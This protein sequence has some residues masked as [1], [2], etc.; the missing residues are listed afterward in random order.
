[1]TA[2]VPRR[3]RPN[4]IDT[5]RAQAMRDCASHLEDLKRAHGRPPADVRV[6]MT[7][8][9]RFIAPVPESSYCTSPALLCAEL[10]K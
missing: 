10:V 3:R 2:S 9:P 7:R 4:K 8:T 6:C 1:M 5:D